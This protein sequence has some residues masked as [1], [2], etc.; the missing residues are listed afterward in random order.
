MFPSSLSVFI[1]N[2][3]L[4]HTLMAINVNLTT[5]Y[6]DQDSGMP[7]FFAVDKSQ[8]WLQMKDQLAGT[9]VLRSNTVTDKSPQS[10]IDHGY[11]QGK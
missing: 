11:F 4:L 3:T 10:L 5:W 7:N 9:D 2:E 6:K 8:L 1:H